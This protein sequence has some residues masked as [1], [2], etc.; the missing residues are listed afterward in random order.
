MSIDSEEREQEKA[1]QQAQKERSEIL[2]AYSTMFSS[3]D[4]EKVL[5]NLTLF[6]DN[7]PDPLVRCGASDLLRH[8]LRMRTRGRDVARPR[9][10]TARVSTSTQPNPQQSTEGE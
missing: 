10:V 8:M 2:L 3:S 6:T 5:N 4:G 1:E 9:S 7:I